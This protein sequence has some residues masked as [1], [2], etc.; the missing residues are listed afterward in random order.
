[1]RKFK[2][3]VFRKKERP[4]SLRDLEKLKELPPVEQ[5]VNFIYQMN[6]PYT[7][8]KKKAESLISDDKG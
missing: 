3:L 5:K 7:E 8:L 1:M 6:N 2:D 4:I